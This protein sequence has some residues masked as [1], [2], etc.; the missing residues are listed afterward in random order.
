METDTTNQA[1]PRAT[2]PDG[3]KVYCSF[4]EIAELDTLKPNPRNPN[5]HPK[6]QIAL[7]ARIIKERGWRANITISKRSGMIVKGHGR[8][9]AAQ[10]AGTKYA[11]I[12]WQDYASDSDET[13]DLIAD[14]RLSEL[15]VLDEQAVTELLAEMEANAEGV[16]PELT[17]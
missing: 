3:F 15:A 5:G 1:P 7:L 10:E 17:V 8:L 4:D 2:T 6:A 9:L 16:D 12:D 13:A 11:P 14:N